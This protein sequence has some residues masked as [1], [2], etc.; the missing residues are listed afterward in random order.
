LFYLSLII[1]IMI[2]VREIL[3]DWLD[4]SGDK[5]VGKRSIP[6]VFGTRGTLGFIFLLLLITTAVVLCAPMLVSLYDWAWYSLI[7][8]LVITWIPIFLIVKNPSE[9]NILFNIRFSHVTFVFIVLGI[10]LR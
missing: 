6:I 7:A 8:A 10:L 4:V 1:F 3:L 2:L 5:A 9:K